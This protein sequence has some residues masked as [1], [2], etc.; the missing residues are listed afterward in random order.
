VQHLAHPGAQRRHRAH[1]GERPGKQRCQNEHRPQAIEQPW[2]QQRD[3]AASDVEEL[4]HYFGAQ[5]VSE[6]HLPH[7][8]Q[9]RRRRGKHEQHRQPGGQRS[10]A[11]AR[12]S[13]TSKA[14]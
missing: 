5:V 4:S 6:L 1:G 12:T 8:E 14:P 3:A 13:S 10:H 7:R 9:Q 2:Q 11:Q